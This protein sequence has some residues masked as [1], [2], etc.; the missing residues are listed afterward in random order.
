MLIP[1][2]WKQGSNEANHHNSLPLF[3]SIFL[4]MISKAMSSISCTKYCLLMLVFR[5]CFTTLDLVLRHLLF[6][7]SACVHALCALYRYACKMWLLSCPNPCA[8][9]IPH[10]CL[11]MYAN[12][13]AP[14][15][16]PVLLAFVLISKHPHVTASGLAQD[17]KQSLG[18]GYHCLRL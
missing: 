17:H 12:C 2:A 18:I 13:C 8:L 16:V 3:F 14:T 7:S 15:R 10:N 9:A 5:T 6:C 11:M 4:G 1:L